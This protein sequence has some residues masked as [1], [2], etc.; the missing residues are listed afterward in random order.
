[1]PEYQTHSGRPHATEEA[2]RTYGDELKEGAARVG[3]KVAEQAQVAA[4]ETGRLAGEIAAAARERPYATI[5][6]AAGLAFALGALWKMR[7]ARQHS[8]LD[9]LL[10][11]LPDL[12]SP[13]SILP[14]SWR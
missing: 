7:T 5:A 14:R 2:A 13:N 9:G 8:N 12:P 4:D 3:E 1:M 10:A 6:I 11:R